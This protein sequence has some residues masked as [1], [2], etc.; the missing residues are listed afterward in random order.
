VTEDLENSD[1]FLYLYLQFLIFH[2]YPVNTNGINESSFFQLFC[3]VPS[4]LLLLCCVGL[5]EKGFSVSYKAELRAGSMA[6]EA[7]RL[8]S[9]CKALSSNTSTTKKKKKKTV[10]DTS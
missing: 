4:D 1:L 8:S 2:R 7:E 6:Q 5:T 3:V 9:K 10:V